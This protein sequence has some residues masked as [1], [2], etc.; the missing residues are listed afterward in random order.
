MGRVTVRIPI[1]LRGYSEGTPEV[2]IEAASVAEA[3]AA[4]DRRC[5]GVLASVCDEAG[6]IRVHVNLFLNQES[7]RAL[8]GLETPTRD[9]D[10]LHIIPAVSGG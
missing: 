9:G 4:L 2:A 7:V 10:V 3:L 6:R 8:A 1:P 5:P